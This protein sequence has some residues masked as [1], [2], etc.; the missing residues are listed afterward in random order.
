[1]TA[2]DPATKPATENPVATGNA[3]TKGGQIRLTRWSPGLLA[4]HNRQPSGKRD[5]PRNGHGFQDSSTLPKPTSK[6]GSWSLTAPWTTSSSIIQ[7][8][9]EGCRPVPPGLPPWRTSWCGS[10][11]HPR[12]DRSHPRASD[13]QRQRDHSRM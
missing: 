1:M 9:R 7:I 5:G 6:S 12:L 13:R 3:S 4:G 8:L 11:V 10:R 2:M